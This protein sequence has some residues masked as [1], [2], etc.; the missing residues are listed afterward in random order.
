MDFNAFRESI[1]L[2]RAARARG[3]YCIYVITIGFGA[4]AVVFDPKGCTIEDYNKL[5][6]DVD[7]NDRERLKVPLGSVAPVLPSYAA[8]FPPDIAQ[9]I[10]DG[11]RPGPSNSVGAG[12]ASILAANE[13][14]R[15]I[16]KKDGIVTAP[17][18]TY[19]DLIDRQVVV[20]TVA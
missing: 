20:G 2:Q 17:K 19:I 8:T 4:L 13:A 15:V 11:K 6:S 12:L 16:L 1:I 7:L 9:E 10:M 5:P 3:I 14:V 18:Y